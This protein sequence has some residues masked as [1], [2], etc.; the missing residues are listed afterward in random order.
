MKNEILYQ[1]YSKNF[2]I[3]NEFIKENENQNKI[4]NELLKEIQNKK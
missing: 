3:I 2:K 1:F 4:M